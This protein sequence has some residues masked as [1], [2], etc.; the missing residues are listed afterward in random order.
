MQNKGRFLFLT[1]GIIALLL[2]SAAS[3]LILRPS[4]SAKAAS[5]PTG[6]HVVG[7]QIEDSSGRVIIPHGVNRMGG[8][9]SCISSSGGTFDGPITQ[10]VV[11]AM[12]SW[13]INIVRVP[14][15]EDCWL[16]ING[17]PVSETSAKYQ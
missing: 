2:F 6:L 1:F 13:D 16:G 4:G 7:N 9:Y 17:E 10:T 8:E 3:I 15:N 14:L 5:A 12:L 11:N